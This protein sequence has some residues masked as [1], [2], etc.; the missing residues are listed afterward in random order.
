MLN[1][2]LNGYHALKVKEKE[3]QDA[4]REYRQSPAFV[5]SRGIV[6]SA[7]LDALEQQRWDTIAQTMDSLR[8]AL[9]KKLSRS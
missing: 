8:S 3:R 4:M 5:Q 1:L 2:T 7:A 9:G 6:Q